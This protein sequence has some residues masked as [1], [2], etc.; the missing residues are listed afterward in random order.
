MLETK[1]EKIEKITVDGVDYA[2]ADLTPELKLL[3]SLYEETFARTK[4]LEREIQVMK[5][6]MQQMGSTL[7]QGIQQT[8]AVQAAEVQA[9]GVEMVGGAANTNVTLDTP[10]NVVPIVSPVNIGIAPA[11]GSANAKN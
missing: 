9:A 10:D 4:D 7:V 8:L 11:T 5:Y 6:S 1:I 3:V 2:T